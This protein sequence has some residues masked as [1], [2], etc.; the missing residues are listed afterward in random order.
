MAH[1]ARLGLAGLD[2]SSRSEEPLVFSKPNSAPTDLHR[3]SPEFSASPARFESRTQRSTW[4]GRQSA[5][6]GSMSLSSAS[7]KVPSLFTSRSLL[8]GSCKPY[9]ANSALSPADGCRPLSQ[10]L[11][12][13]QV[14]NTELPL[15]LSQNPQGPFHQATA[16]TPSAQTAPSP[17]PLKSINK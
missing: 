1:A 14:S 4:P 16:R 7:S 15:Q 9:C 13:S 11:P 12:I 17:P 3:A 2:Q 6:R 8:G 10:Y 5:R